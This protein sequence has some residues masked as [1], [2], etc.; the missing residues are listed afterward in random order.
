MLTQFQMMGTQVRSV[1]RNLLQYRRQDPE[2][3]L[4]WKNHEL[5]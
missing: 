4:Q 1:T 2:F 5:S 3:V